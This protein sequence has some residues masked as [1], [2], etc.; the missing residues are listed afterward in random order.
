MAAPN[1]ALE[2]MLVAFDKRP[3]TPDDAAANLRKV[4]TANP[5]LLAELN[6][7][8]AN[9]QLKH[10][11]VQPAD[12][13]A[14]GTFDPDHA[15]MRLPLA[16]LRDAPAGHFDPANL[17]F[18]L[19][20]EVQHGLN[21]PGMAA[22]K[23]TFE[24]RVTAIAKSTSPVHDYTTAIGDRIAASRRDEARAEI[25]GWNALRGAL[26][27]AGKAPT[28]ELMY[29]A[30]SFRM[31]DFIT[32]NDAVHPP[33]YALKPGLAVNA[34]LSMPATAANI[35]A[36][37]TH[38]FDQTPAESHLGAKGTSDYRNYYGASAVSRAIYL[39]R[40]YAAQAHHPQARVDIG[41]SKLGLDEAIL[42]TNGI[43]LGQSTA[44]PQRVFDPGTH[45]PTPHTFQHTA[46]THVHVPVD[47]L[48]EPARDAAGDTL[49]SSARD[50]VARLDATLGRA[51]DAASDAMA[52]SLAAAGA[53]AGMT[54]I[55][56]ALLNVATPTERAGRTV[57]G[58]QGEPGSEHGRWV[59][60]PTERA[61][62]PA[63]ADS[64]RRG[65]DVDVDV[66]R[67]PFATPDRVE[68]SLHGASHTADHSRAPS[69]VR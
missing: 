3:D 29:E 17:A 2:A 37:G 61:V 23:K 22:A 33:T 60:L 48:P 1:K 57:F 32:R 26:V 43:H 30:Q 44:T 55:D 15:T 27:G 66:A 16:A 53:R 31:G 28:L 6:A 41:L 42:E 40:F 62:D 25:S 46:T 50:A 7:A 14:G 11:A 12:E 49:R 63:T 20:H 8:A 59:A 39:D 5:V 19:G 18:V 69:L 13:H 68:P 52:E 21:A 34:D 9:G 45:P 65:V 56:H 47:S 36:M 64:L 67:M 51:A 4:I 10:F 38:Y 58:V 35:E 54:R 24:D